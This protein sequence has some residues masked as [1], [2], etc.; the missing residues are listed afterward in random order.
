MPFGKVV[1][2]ELGE[3]ACVGVG[4]G[5]WVR[6]LWKQGG[7]E[8]QTAIRKQLHL[9]WPAG[10]QMKDGPGA[11]VAMVLLAASTSTPLF[12]VVGVQFSMFLYLR[13][14]L[15]TV[16]AEVFCFVAAAFRC[17]PAD[18]GL[19]ATRLVDKK[20]TDSVPSATAMT[21]RGGL[22]LLLAP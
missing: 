9:N 16:A 10:A 19:K 4:Y 13:P 2:F 17:R 6:V 20:K 7:L 22:L 8:C 18:V 11:G 3:E 14:M 12:K 21:S 15:L 1:S 5:G